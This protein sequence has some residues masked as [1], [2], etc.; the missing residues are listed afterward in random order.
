MKK[1]FFA[2]SALLIISLFAGCASRDDSPTPEMTLMGSGGGMDGAN[3]GDGDYLDPNALD[4]GLG[5]EGRSGS[6][7]GGDGF[8]AVAGDETARIFF[9]FDRS[10]IRESERPKLADA[11]GVISAAGNQQV[12]LVG[13]CDYLGTSEYNLGLGDRRATAVKSYLETL[14]IPSNR[15]EV[16]SKGDLEAQEGASESE[17]QQDR[18]VDIFL[19][20]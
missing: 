13:H 3:A 11:A 2:L 8:N 10:F 14:G 1:T 15:M 7:V 18:R 9:D 5:L 12:L 4:G 16:L 6:M 20:P 19:I 17:R